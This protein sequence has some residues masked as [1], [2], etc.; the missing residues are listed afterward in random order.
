MKSSKVKL[1][2]Q[3]LNI[4]ITMIKYKEHPKYWVIHKEVYYNE[5]DSLDE[6]IRDIVTNK[7]Y[8]SS[9]RIFN[10]RID[11]LVIEKIQESDIQTK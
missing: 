5:L 3:P 2:L 6:E 11:R 1:P 8:D 4:N 7:P 9:T 10:T